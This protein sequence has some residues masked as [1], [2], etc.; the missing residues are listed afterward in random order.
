M[1]K[2]EFTNFEITAREIIMSITIIFVMLI[3]GLLISNRINQ[4]II[5][6]NEI[7]NK[8]IKIDSAE[9]FQY[10]MRTNIGNAFVSGTISPIDVVQDE[11]IDGK[12]LYLKKVKEQYTMHTRRVPHKSGKH[13]YYT[14]QV[15]WTWDYVS[16]EINKSKKIKFN[17]VEFDYDKIDISSE[18]KYIDTINESSIIRYVYYGVPAKNYNGTIFTKLKN[19]TITETDFIINKNTKEAYESM[20]ETS[21]LPVIIFWMLWIILIVALVLIFYYIDNRWLY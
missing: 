17:N 2:I 13:T 11:K 1:R 4:N 6:K 21:K 16:S 14:T 20:I 9:L 7:Y 19:N 15:Y 18:S 10:G 12:Y 3:I 5:D 8:A